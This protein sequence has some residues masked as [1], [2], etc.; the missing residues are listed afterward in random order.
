MGGD[1]S[2]H[3]ERL[4]QAARRAAE[5]AYAPYS[6]F[7]VGAAILTGNGEIFSG[8]NVENASYGGAICA[9]RTAV[10][11]AVSEGHTRFTAI[12]VACEKSSNSWP[13]GICRQFICEF[14]IDIEVV[15]EKND[16]SIESV[17]LQNLLP[18]HFGPAD[19][20]G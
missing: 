16:G 14:G 11:K 17:P 2:E 6:H 10:V 20:P 5:N 3:R 1:I 4:I 9:E 19:L 12:A 8:C 13:C 7:Y 18:K 15:V